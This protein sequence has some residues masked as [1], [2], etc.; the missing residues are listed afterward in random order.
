[1]F[2]AHGRR[3]GLSGNRSSLPF[4]T[5][6]KSGAPSGVRGAGPVSDEAFA[7]IQLSYTFGSSA[8]VP[9]LPLFK[10]ISNRRRCPAPSTTFESKNGM[11]ENPGIVTDTSYVPAG[12]FARA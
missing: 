2:A 5:P 6:E 8:T 12:I 7:R 1:M 4:H 9:R 11:N 10:A 3:A